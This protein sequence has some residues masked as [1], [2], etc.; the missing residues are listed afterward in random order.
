MQKTILMIVAVVMGQSVLAA[1]QN[2][3]GLTIKSAIK[4]SLGMQLVYVPP[5]KFLMG[6]PE[7][8]PGREKQERQH[9]VILTRGFYLGTHEVTVGQF[10]Q[11]IRDA[12]YQTEGERDGKG[13]WGVNASGSIGQNGRYTWKTPGFV[14]TNDHPVVLVSWND[15][16]TFCRWLSKKEKRRYRLPTEAEWEYACR[17]GTRTAYANGDAPKNLKALGNAGAGDDHRFTAPVGTFKPNA[18]GLYD[19][20]GNVWE[21]CTDWYVPGSYPKT[22]QADPVGPASGDARVQRGGGWSSAAKRCRSAARIGRSPS[23]YRG[24][25]LGFRVV[26][27]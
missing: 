23:D 3:N 4:N 12:K 1:E 25:Y 14:Q 22:R 24:S 21:W 11:F 20:H 26:L 19:M 18:F 15:T 6:S 9:E 8:E 27:K 5:G 10:R 16:V 7:T 17:S 2:S 13:G